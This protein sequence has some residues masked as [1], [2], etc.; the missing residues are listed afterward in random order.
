MKK[1]QLLFLLCFP[2]Y[3]YGQQPDMKQQ[4][5]MVLDKYAQYWSYFVAENAKTKL[6]AT[7][8][9]PKLFTDRAQIY[10]QTNHEYLSVSEFTPQISNFSIGATLQMRDIQFCRN[11]DALF[12]VFYRQAYNGKCLQCGDNEDLP[13]LYHRMSVVKTNGNW[14]ISKIERWTTQA[15][16]ADDDIDAI[17]N[18]CDVCPKTVGTL[19]HFGDDPDDSCKKSKCDEPE[20]V[21]VPGGTFQMGSNDGE[22]DEKPVHPVTVRSFRMGKYE[23]TL[24]QFRSFIQATNYQTDAEKE[25]DSYVFKN[26]S[27]QTEK[28]VTWRCDV[29]GAVRSQSDDKH[30]VIHVSWND[31]IEYCKWLSACTGKTYR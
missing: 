16:Q 3:I 18:Q 30:P 5:K 10:E 6:D 23:V 24:G 12:Y 7:R 31:A 15:R 20:T 25:G 28:G 14:L 1:T 17:P 21:L 13:P 11:G 29:T 19:E 4:L 26:N 8:D 2:C 22:S 27:W 9:F